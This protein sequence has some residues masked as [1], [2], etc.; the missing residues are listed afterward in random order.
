MAYNINKSNSDPVTIPSGAIDNQFD[1][2][3]IGQDAINYGDDLALAFVRLLENFANTSA[4]AFGSARTTGQL[5]YDTTGTGTLKIYDG[6]SFVAIPKTSEVVQN[7][8]NES[9]AGVK[10]FSGAPAFNG[11]TSGVDAPFTVDSTFLVTNLN[12]DLLDDNEASVFATFNTGAQRVVGKETMWVPADVMAATAAGG[13]GAVA[14][15]ATSGSNPD[16]RAIPFATGSA[17]SAQFQ[18]AFPK[19]W[20]EGTVTFQVFWSTQSADTGTVEWDLQGVA[21]GS[22]ESIDVAYGTAV[23]VSGAAQGI[24]NL[25]VTAESAAVTIAGTPGE[26]NMTFFKIT[27][28]GVT[29]THTGSAQLIGVKIFWTSNA[30]TDDV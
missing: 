20:D 15:L 30:A 21:M 18:V 23:T 9:I 22:T 6:A 10:T 11:G 4:P 16:L 7:T 24:N 8:G 26:D 1:I 27:R 25:V 29:D 19:R 17:T 14:S 13:A 28:D 3:L 2:P 5:W 12:A